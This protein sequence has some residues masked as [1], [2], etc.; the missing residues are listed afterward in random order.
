MPGSVVYPDGYDEFTNPSPTSSFR[1]GETAGWL[2]ETKQNDALTAIE[3]L[4]GKADGSDPGT[5]AQRIQALEGAGPGSTF[6]HQQAI[7]ATTWVVTH[8][9]SKFPSVIAVDGGLTELNGNLRYINDQTL[10][11]DFA[12][13]TGGTA[14][15]N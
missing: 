15:L 9:L 5:L 2:Q 1:R 4:V 3:H 11:L 13:A 7:P 10:E 12:F 14:Y 6:I 8:N